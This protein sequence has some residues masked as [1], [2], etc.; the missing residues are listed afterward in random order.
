MVIIKRPIVSLISLLA[1]KALVFC[2]YKLLFFD[3]CF[4]YSGTQ[5]EHN[6]KGP[7]IVAYDNYNAKYILVV[8]V[9]QLIWLPDNR[10][11]CNGMFQRRDIYH[12]I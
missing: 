10:I 8:E 11:P 4:V 12:T 5:T 1:T 2:L 9:G 3:Y 6:T 7:H